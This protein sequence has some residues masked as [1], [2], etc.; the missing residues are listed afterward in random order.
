MYTFFSLGKVDQS[1]SCEHTFFCLL[2][3]MDGM[4]Q[5]DV[6]S[7][8]VPLDYSSACP[9]FPGNLPFKMR[10]IEYFFLPKENLVVFT[11]LS[12]LHLDACLCFHIYNSPLF[13]CFSASLFVSWCLFLFI[14]FARDYKLL[15]GYRHNQ[16]Y[17]VLTN[18]IQITLFFLWLI[19]F[20]QLHMLQSFPSCLVE[21]YK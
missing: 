9:C 8:S 13:F 10:F 19:L 4:E 21:C 18:Q 16:L 5:V 20:H 1:L 3:Q 6:V 11:V 12:V 2:S 15:Q 17:C 7:Y 14:C